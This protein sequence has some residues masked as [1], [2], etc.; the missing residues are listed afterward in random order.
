MP[1][2]CWLVSL[3]HNHSNEAG[4][5]TG[6]KMSTRYSSTKVFHFSDKVNS[7]PFATGQVLPPLHVRIKPTNRCAHNCWYCAYKADSLQLGSDMNKRDDIPLDKMLE[8]ITDLDRMGVSAVTFSGGGD[9][10]YYPHLKETL[11]ALVDTDIKFASLT[12]GAK[13]KGELADI[14]AEHG[15]WLRVSIDGWDAASYAKY[16]GVSEKEFPK[17]MNNLAAFAKK[18]GNCFLGV[19]LIVD[20]DNA[21]HLNEFVGSLKDTGVDSVKI[22]PCIVSNDGRENNRYHEPIYRRVREQVN[23]AIQNYADA[24]FE[25]F[26]AYH[27]LDEKFTKAYDWCP[28]VQVLTVIGADQK[29]YSCQDKA[30]NEKG[31]LGDIRQQ[32]FADFWMS[33]KNNFFKVKPSRDCNHHCVANNKNRMI[34]EYLDTEHIEFV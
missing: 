28:Y 16:R 25:I 11:L 29:V 15:S 6:P 30:Y 8:I 17:V 13:L 20:Q 18:D 10:F 3:L 14:F 32:S 5:L 31:E 2:R 19:S 9:P 34:L 1:C 7:L 33:D 4:I 22:S 24:D 26:D 12:N 21:G 23:T 27:E